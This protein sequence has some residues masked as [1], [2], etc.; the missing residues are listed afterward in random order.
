M[1]ALPSLTQD[2]H[3][4][5]RF[6]T[7]PPGNHRGRAAAEIG[8]GKL[9]SPQRQKAQD[10]AAKPGSALTDAVPSME[11]GRTLNAGETILAKNPLL[12]ANHERVIHGT[13][14]SSLQ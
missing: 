7:I 8:R 6:D 9:N 12:I 3:P 13:T 5:I 4:L 1:L 10:A 11:T 14:A 2:W